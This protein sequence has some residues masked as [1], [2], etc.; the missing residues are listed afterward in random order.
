[1]KINRIA[2]D[3]FAGLTDRDMRF[4]DGLNLVIGDNE[5]GK[6]TMIDLIYQLFFRGSKLNRRSDAE[7]IRRYFPRKVSG[8]EGDVVDGTI[9]YE[10]EEGTFRLKKEWDG[11][12][13]SCRLTLPDGTSIKDPER[14]GQVLKG[15]LEYR[16]G[17]YGE[18]V[19]ASRKRR[20]LAVRS[21]MEKLGR[22]SSDLS[23]ARED[24]TSVLARASLET[25]GVSIDLIGKKIRE[26]LDL[27]GGRWDAEADAPEGGRKRASYKDRWTKGTGAL[28]EAYYAAD[29][30]RTRQ[31][32]EEQAERAVDRESG[33]IRELKDQR[34]AADEQKKTF[35]RYSGTIGQIRLLEREIEAADRQAAEYEQTLKRWPK[36]TR[37]LE[38][39]R[40]LKAEFTQTLAMERYSEVKKAREAWLAEKEELSKLHKVDAA[41]VRQA[42][43]LTRR[44]EREEGR[45]RGMN[46]S[47]R[48]R[49]LGEADVK[50]IRSASGREILTEDGQ[51]DIT[52]AVRIL[53]P[54]VAEV[55]LMPKGTDAEEVTKTAAKLRGERKEIYDRYGVGSPEELHDLA[56]AY[57]GASSLLERLKMR[58][59]SALGKDAW[60]DLES[61]ALKVPEGTRSLTEV[62]SS[63]LELCGSASLDTFIGSCQAALDEYIRKY[64]SPDRLLSLARENLNNRDK[65]RQKI[66]AAGDVPDMLRDIADPESYGRQLQDRIDGIDSRIDTCEASL[67][68][69][70]RA[71]GEKSSEEYSEEL[72]AQERELGE[73][74]E[75]YRR[76]L[77]IQ[78]VFEEMKSET[79]GRCGDDIAD[80]FRRYLGLITRGTLQLTGMDGQ[81][82]ASLSSG[83][84]ALSYDTLSDGT[85]DTVSLAFRL[86]M[87]EH[88]FPEGDGIAV[89]DDPFTDMDP[90]RVKE[91]CALIEEFAKKNQVIFVTCDGKYADYLKGHVITLEGDR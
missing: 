11:G 15:Q 13:G 3:Q 91:A 12:E 56:A 21:I 10:T 4:S 76:W 54:G 19:F 34:K 46:L 86:A 71:L 83:Q 69:A 53:I 25:G 7:F 64:E 78:A 38:Y 47:A 23:E 43:L 66:K 67:R 1:M 6:S 42:D 26:K 63:I 61:A 27:L 29:E 57:D 82:S 49:K 74:K 41:D 5:T 58:Y 28:A 62:R 24:L 51:L 68:E 16:E 59:D 88:I 40:S 87:L 9:T 45:L 79:G 31:L 85:R 48:I 36:V 73:L 55:D 8:V 77:H 65:C 2:C 70:E 33:R 35:L 75:E 72:S 60:E 32:E 44:I 89:F 52:E 37:N 50:I 30:I 18:I 17:V 39:A 22:K 90:G 81:L 84:H 20:Q 14:I 80:S